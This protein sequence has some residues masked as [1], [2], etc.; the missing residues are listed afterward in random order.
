MTSDSSL[1]D[2]CGAGQARAMPAQ[3]DAVPRR[4]GLI[5][6]VIEQLRAQI[7]SGTWQVGA[8]IPTEPE[9]VELTGTGRNTVREA[10]QALV[11]AGLLE[12]RQGS[13]TYVVADSEL[14]VAVGRRV[15]GARHRDVLEVR[16]TLEVGCA[17]LAATRR[18]AEDSQRLQE[19]LARRTAARMAGDVD[20][21][22]AVD[23]QLH[24]AIAEA[25]RN[26]VLADLYRDLL[27][28]IS[29]SVAF[30]VTRL[31]PIE[32]DDHVGLVAAIVDGDPERAA[33]EAA[34]FLDE[35][36]RSNST[37]QGG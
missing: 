14:A 24:L 27:G 5:D 37:A 15:A 17:R 28:A 23:V 25:S 3:A 34:R 1:P 13:G 4:S 7:S 19:L 29:E 11:H 30:N 32:D 31:P 21:T 22:I 33:R 8:R 35:L 26:Q 6:R 18:T 9:L 2:P 16:R 20:A 36:L 10:V 12:R